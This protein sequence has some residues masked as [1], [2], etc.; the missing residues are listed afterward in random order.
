VNLYHFLPIEKKLTSPDTVTSSDVPF[1]FNGDPNSRNQI[2]V[3]TINHDT[4]YLSFAGTKVMVHATLDPKAFF[5]FESLGAEDLKLYGEIAFIGL[6]QSNAYN[7][8]YG[9]IT[10]RMPV[11]V[12]FNFPVFKY[13]DNLSLEVEWYGSHVKDDL[14]RLQAT[15]GNFQSPLPVVNNAGLNLDRDNWKWSL[16]ATKTI[17]NLQFSFQAANDHTRPGG[18]WFS[19]GSEWQAY[20]VTPKD[21]YWLA[22]MGFFF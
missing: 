18:T 3:D 1:S 16:H 4:T 21:W 19:P 17:R 2:Y 15:T 20:F 11:M 9:T 5:D 13:I 22:K 12:G 7:A 6:N 8:V 10:K 14:G